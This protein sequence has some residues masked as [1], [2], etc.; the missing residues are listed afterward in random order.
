[1]Y[2]L[3]SKVSR[4]E[5]VFGKPQAWLFEWQKVGCCCGYQLNM[6]SLVDIVIC[7]DASEMLSFT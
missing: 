6:G 2:D 3:K 5:M 4:S 1:M 7:A